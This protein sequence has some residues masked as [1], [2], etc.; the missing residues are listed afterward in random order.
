[1]YELSACVCAAA[2][3]QPEL[4][5]CL[6][7]LVS[8][9][10]PALLATSLQGGRRAAPWPGGLAGVDRGVDRGAELPQGHAENSK[11]ASTS[12]ADLETGSTL[13]PLRDRQAEFTAAK[14]LFFACVPSTPS[15]LDLVS[16]LRDAAFMS[17][18][19]PLDGYLSSDSSGAR[20]RG[21]VG[22]VGCWGHPLFRYALDMLSALAIP[23]PT[24]VLSLAA[25]APT[26][27]LQLIVMGAADRARG[28]LLR[29]LAASFRNLPWQA[30]ER[31]L[32]FCGATCET[33]DGDAL[34][35]VLQSSADAGCRGAQHAL[36]KL[37]QE[38]WDREGERRGDLMF[39]P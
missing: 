39:R 36:E 8:D 16:V 21:A 17:I 15:K 9:L 3:N 34:L 6:Q 10:H 12:S 38:A 29:S 5:K 26:P 20:A 37:K 2:G 35:A 33:E 24:K 23:D 13:R 28:L 25:R 31:M 30:A 11:Q 1:M 7:V 18:V 14:L 27:L 32:G 19:G 4:L 22:S